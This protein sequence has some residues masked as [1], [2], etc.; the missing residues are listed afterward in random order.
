MV[1]LWYAWS[2]RYSVESTLFST[3]D[4]LGYSDVMCTMGLEFG[5]LSA[6]K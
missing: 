3:F 2:L 4:L 1:A 5:E 6:E